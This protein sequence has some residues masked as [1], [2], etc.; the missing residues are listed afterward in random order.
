MEG[1]LVWERALGHGNGDAAPVRFVAV[2]D[3]VVL[4]IEA[5]L[6]SVH[7]YRL[8]NGEALGELTFDQTDLGLDE[9][10]PI[11]Y[12]RGLLCG[13]DGAGVAAYDVRTGEKRW[14][15]P[16]AGRLVS[17]FAPRDGR[18]VV[19]T[20]DAEH[21]LCDSESG[22]VLFNGRFENFNF[23]AVDGVLEEGVLILANSR[24]VDAGVRWERIGAEATGRRREIDEPCS[25]RGTGMTTR[26]QIA[27][28][29][30]KQ[31]SGAGSVGRCA[32]SIE[33]ASSAATSNASARRK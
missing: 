17:V 20:A 14:S 24:A 10:I 15:L 31:S 1:G 19:S 23:G 9:P 13:P 27:V 28:V 11:Q 6:E 32:S 33:T 7:I 3:D 21:W 4:T 8:D 2:G 22:E 29:L 26:G 12:S 30:T 25:A 18:L 16:L 5:R